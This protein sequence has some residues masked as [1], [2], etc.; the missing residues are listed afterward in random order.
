MVIVVG[1]LILISVSIVA[2]KAYAWGLA[3]EMMKLFCCV[4][5]SLRGCEMM[6]APSGV[7]SRVGAVLRYSGVVMVSEER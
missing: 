6:Y 3:K 4:D 7:G 2:N 5:V 1:S